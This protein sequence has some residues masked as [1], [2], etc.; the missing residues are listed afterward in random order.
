M[1]A[2]SRMNS[3]ADLSKIDETRSNITVAD[4][5][6]IDETRSNITVEERGLAVNE[7][8]FDRQ[9]HTHHM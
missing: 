5:S 3:Y 2:S 1:T 8:N 4:L 9:A 7:R 6:E